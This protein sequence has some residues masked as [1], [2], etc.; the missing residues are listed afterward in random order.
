MTTENPVS[1]LVASLCEALNSNDIQYCHWKSNAAIDRSASGEND[2]DL[3]VSRAHSE[4]FLEI[5]YAL[6]FREACAATVDKLPGV[7]DFYGYDA[8]VDR[9]IHVHAHFQ[10]VL[11]HDFTKNYRLPIETAYLESSTLTGLFKIPSV[12]FELAILVLRLVIKHSTLDAILMRHGAL[13]KSERAELDYLQERTSVAQAA[14]VIEKHLPCLDQG[15]FEVCL[16]ALERGSS[17]WG[18]ILAGKRL[19]QQLETCARH[20][21]VRDLF[22]KLTLRVKLPIQSRLQLLPKKCMANGGLMIAIIGGDGSGKTTAINGLYS[23]LNEEF[24]IRKF[25]MGKPVWSLSTIL[26]RGL[27]KVGRTLGFYPFMKE[28]TEYSIDTD[29]PVFPGYPWLIREVCTAHDRMLTYTRAR[30]LASNGALVICDRYPLAQVRIMDGPQVERVTHGMKTNRL[31]E[32]LARLEKGYY[33]KILLPD[34][35]AVL[36]VAPEIS[37]E[38]KTD[39]PAEF[40]PLSRHRDLECGLERNPRKDDRR[41]QAKS[42]RPF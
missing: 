2:L 8:R 36:R 15:L 30:R 33:E 5:L 13:S 28:G 23:R 39:E 20:P 9:I 24:E 42:R 3:L 4:K 31:I 22:Q 25:H 1:P 27:V 21:Q 11:G 41:R 19:Q 29:K 12:E 38:R 35:L 26:I 40:G 32:F 6:G 10:L 34:L 37:V 17:F 14:A 16:H 7:R 18:R